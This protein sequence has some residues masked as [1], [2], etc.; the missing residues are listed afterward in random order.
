MSEDNAFDRVRDD[1]IGIQRIGV[2]REREQAQC[3]LVAWSLL[4]EL[5]HIEL[6]PPSHDRTTVLDLVDR[7]KR[8]IHGDIR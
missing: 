7:A 6:A 3:I 8:L 4:E 5:A 1:A 2:S